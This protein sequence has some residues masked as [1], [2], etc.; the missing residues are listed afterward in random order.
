MRRLVD[1]NGREVVSS[2]T[3]CRRGLP[4]SA[5]GGG[6]PAWCAGGTTTI[7]SISI[8]YEHKQSLSVES[9]RVSNVQLDEV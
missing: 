4:K 1:K 7:T 2:S 3:T 9:I 5:V 6:A 8:M